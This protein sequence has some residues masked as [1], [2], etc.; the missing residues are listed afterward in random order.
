MNLSLI[1]M[2][3][4]KKAAFMTVINAI[5]KQVEGYTM[6]GDS[7]SQFS[8]HL[9]DLITEAA[10]DC[11]GVIEHIVNVYDDVVQVNYDHS[12]IIKRVSEDIRD[13]YER[14][15]VIQRLTHEYQAAEK[16]YAKAKNEW[17][18]NKGKI[19]E[20]SFKQK[21]IDC[22]QIT[23]NALTTLIEQKKKMWKFTLRRVSHAVSFYT[24]ALTKSSEKEAELMK[25]AVFIM[26]KEA[27]QEVEND[28]NDNQDQP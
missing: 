16:N 18:K 15:L 22:L 21:A 23:K 25:Q 6:M 1:D 8:L 2:Q 17:I 9:L 7:L 14:N 13:I 11:I 26:Q 5:S 19:T 3:D 20:S 28:T 27:I 10:P 4:P 12:K 24:V